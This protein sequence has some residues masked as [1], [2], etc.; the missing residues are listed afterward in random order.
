MAQESVLI[1]NRVVPHS[2][3]V[4]LPGY[5]ERGCCPQDHLGASIARIVPVST[6]LSRLQVRLAPIEVSLCNL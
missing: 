3:P 6:C 5:C 2:L 4:S 1:L